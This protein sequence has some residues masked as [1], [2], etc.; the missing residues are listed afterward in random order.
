MTAESL[1]KSIVSINTPEAGLPVS[2]RRCLGQRD[3][4]VVLVDRCADHRQ[5]GEVVSRLEA[6]MRP[7]SPAELLSALGLLARLTRE[8]PAD[9]EAL[10]F[11]VEVLCGYPAD[12]ALSALRAWPEGS[13]WWPSPAELTARLDPQVAARRW[14]LT[15]LRRLLD[16]PTESLDSELRRRLAA[17]VEAPEVVEEVLRQKPHEIAELRGCLLRGESVSDAA[18]AALAEPVQQR[19]RLDREL[20]RVVAAQLRDGERVETVLAGLTAVERADWL[21]CLAKGATARLDRLIAAHLGTLR[22]LP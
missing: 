17:L 14:L 13:K 4:A 2:V 19:R 5:L 12:L 3:G 16:W 20:H 1:T 6:A 15:L 9:R 18:L 22:V 7:A 8:A 10:G 11:Y 21:A